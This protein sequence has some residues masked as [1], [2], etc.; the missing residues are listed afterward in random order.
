MTD[1]N[2]KHPSMDAIRWVRCLTPSFGLGT[3]EGHSI[4]EPVT[5]PQTLKGPQYLASI[6]SY[7]ILDAD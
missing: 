3:A 7:F 6:P 1:I 4:Q 2:T 5:H